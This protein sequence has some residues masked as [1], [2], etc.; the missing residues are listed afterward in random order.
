MRY[1]ELHAIT[2]KLIHKCSQMEHKFAQMLKG[3]GFKEVMIRY[4]LADLY[5]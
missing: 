5:P 3:F 1:P 2:L 4:S